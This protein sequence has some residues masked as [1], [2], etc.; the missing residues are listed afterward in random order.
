LPAGATPAKNSS[1]ADI[2]R[3]RLTATLGDPGVVLVS[4]EAG[5]GKSRLG[6][7]RLVLQG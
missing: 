7:G 1:T 2:G 5:I 4:G 6:G 3:D